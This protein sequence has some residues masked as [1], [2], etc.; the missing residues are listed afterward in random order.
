MPSQPTPFSPVDKTDTQHDGTEDL[1]INNTRLHRFLTL[2]ALKTLAKLHTHN[3]DCIAITKHKIVKTGI[4][5]HLTEAATMQFVDQN[6]S[7]IPTPKVHCAFVRKNRAYIV[8]QRIHGRGFPAAW[9][10]HNFTEENLAKIFNQ[11]KQ[12]FEELCAIKTPPDTGGRRE[13]RREIHPNQ[14]PDK[15]DQDWLDIKDMV[16]KQDGPWPAP[17]FTH[18]D[19]DPFNILLRGDEVVGIID[20]E[21]AGWFPYYWEYTVAYTGNATRTGWRDLIDRFLEPFPDELRMEGIRQK[22]WGEF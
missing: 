15:D 18:G 16:T 12:M 2:L 5:V 10:K 19:L 3:G 7:S 22:W 1:S 9:R 21:C 4:W 17:V 14:Y 8:M 11:L 20:W 6:T 13:L